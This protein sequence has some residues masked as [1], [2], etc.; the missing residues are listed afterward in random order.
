[1]RQK[2]G[3]GISDRQK[4]KGAIRFQLFGPDGKLKSETWGTNLLTELM[5]AQVAD[6]MSDDTDAAIGYLSVGTG[7]GQDAADTG[8]AT[9]LARV[10][11]DSTTQGAAGADNDVVYVATFGAGVGTDAIT[12]AGLMRLDDDASLMTYDDFA[13]IK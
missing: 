3:L 2:F 13:V 6:Q 10:A 5:D 11:L 4:M 9:T 1:M 7:T 8:M 12:E